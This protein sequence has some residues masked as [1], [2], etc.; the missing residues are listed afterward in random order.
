M[1][2]SLNQTLSIVTCG[3]GNLREVEITLRSIKNFQ[4]GHPRII[5]ILSDFSDNEIR[6]L[7]SD[8][9]DLEM[10]IFGVPAEGV[11]AAMNYAIDQV[12]EGY[13]LFLNA[14]DAIE[15]ESALSELIQ[16]CYPDKWGYGR[17]VI[18]SATSVYKKIYRFSPYIQILHLTGLKYVPHPSTIVPVRLF[19]ELGNFNLKYP[20]A[21][22]QEF[23]IRC[24]F[25][26][27]PI[28]LDRNISNFQ[29]GGIS[30]RAPHEIVRDFRS[31]SQELLPMSH[32]LN[33]PIF[34]PW[35]IILAL[36]K[37]RGMQPQKDIDLNPASNF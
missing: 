28:V 3:K 1:N 30:T 6:K 22:D 5:L 35:W 13:I 17:A 19:R 9:L 20:I 12:R 14:G 4:A 36:R 24:S 16:K 29:L 21:A 34:N 26:S 11:Y 10:I 37:I 23:L 7:E 2:S 25:H 32:F 31:I 33:W 18:S 27:K 8:F 15:S